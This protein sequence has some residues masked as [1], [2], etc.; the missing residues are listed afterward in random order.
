[1][2]FTLWHGILSGAV[3]WI[4]SHRTGI[5]HINIFTGPGFM[6]Q[7]IDSSPFFDLKLKS[8]EYITSTFEIHYSIFDIPFFLL[9]SSFDKMAASTSSATLTA[10]CTESAASRIGLPITR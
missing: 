10:A 7:V 9:H 3:Q 4:Q 5:L 8:I 6:R 2:L 1:M